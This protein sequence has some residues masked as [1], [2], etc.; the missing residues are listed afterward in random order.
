METLRLDRFYRWSDCTLGVVVDKNNEIVCYSLERPWIDNKPNISCIP[1][2]TYT[3]EINKG[4]KKGFRLN[5]VPGRKD[6]LIHVGN[7]IKDSQGCLLWGASAGKLGD[8]D[9][10]K[11]SAIMINDLINKYPNGFI[12]EIRNL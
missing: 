11:E 6:I 4:D 12:L 2:G 3:V 5:N 9:G 1:P 10:V 8:V 7:T